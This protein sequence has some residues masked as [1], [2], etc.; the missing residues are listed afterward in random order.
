ML[1]SFLSKFVLVSSGCH[2]RVPQT[3]GLTQQTFTVSQ[4]QWLGIQGRGALRVGF[5]CIFCAI[6]ESAISLG[7]LG[8]FYWRIVLE[9]K[10]W[11]LGVLAATE[12]SLPSCRPCQP[13]KLRT[14]VCA[15]TCAHTHG[16]NYFYG[17][18]SMFILSSAWT[19]TAVSD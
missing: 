15:L 1:Y 8:S 13:R 7:S 19:R 16:C 9:T 3:W 12:V 4:S 6:L 17:K 10:I 18:P 14:Y 5:S 11:V 2:N